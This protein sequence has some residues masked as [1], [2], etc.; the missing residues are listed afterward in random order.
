MLC[1]H[2]IKFKNF[3]IVFFNLGN[4]V[5]TLGVKKKMNDISL[6]ELLFKNSVCK[7]FVN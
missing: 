6:D 3:N 4:C 2:L 7:F 5:E 1:N